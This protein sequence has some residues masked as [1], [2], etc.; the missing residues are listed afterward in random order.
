M[1]EYGRKP[2]LPA[3]PS[4]SGKRLE[5]TLYSINMQSYLKCPYL[6]AKTVLFSFFCLTKDS[7]HEVELNGY[8]MGN[9]WNRFITKYSESRV[10]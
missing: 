10:V 9:G 6:S 4:G 7:K 1:L 5:A 2:N 3:K 8:N